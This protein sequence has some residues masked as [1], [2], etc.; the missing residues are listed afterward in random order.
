MQAHLGQKV[1]ELSRG[2]WG[3]IIDI[4]L[5]RREICVHF[6][7][8]Q[9]GC[10][11]EVW[12]EKK[13]LRDFETKRR[14]SFGPPIATTYLYYYFNIVL[15]SSIIVFLSYK[16]VSHKI[17]FFSAPYR[18]WIKLKIL[19]LESWLFLFPLLWLVSVVFLV[20]P[21]LIL[22]LRWRKSRI[23]IRNQLKIRALQET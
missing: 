2:N 8:N 11:A 13:H 9:T 14:L 21:A 4:D 22:W 19:H 17:Y 18:Y 23:W 5:A 6:K 16:M 7:N 12:F 3:R 15:L 10:E 20:P 1:W